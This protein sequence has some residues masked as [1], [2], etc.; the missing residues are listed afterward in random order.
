VDKRIVR[1]IV[2]VALLGILGGLAGCSAEYRPA[3]PASQVPATSPAPVGPSPAPTAAR[4]ASPTALLT[5]AAAGELLGVSWDDRSV[6]RSGLL[7]EAQAVLEHLPGA[8]VYQVDLR[9]P[10]DLN[11]LAGRESV[12]YTNQEAA[13][14][15]EV[16][17]QL[18]PNAAGGKTTV[19][20]VQVNG[21]PVK[22]TLEYE[23]STLRVPLPAA[24]QPGEQAVVTMDFEVEVPREMGGNY[25]LFGYFDGVLVLD[26]FYPVIPVYDDEGWNVQDPPRNADTSYFDMSFYLVRV[27]APAN[28]IL[29]ASGVPVD[30]QRTGQEQVVTLAAGP[31]RDFYIAASAGFTA[32]S[33]TVDGIKV[34]SYAPSDLRP[35]TQ[36][37]LD[38]AARALE[39]YG[40]RFGPYPYTEFDVVSTP[41][42]ALGIEYPGLTGIALSL[43]DLGGNARGTPNSVMVESTVAHEVGHQ[44]FYNLVGNDQIDEPWLDESVVQYVTGLYYRDTYGSSAEQSLQQSWDGRWARVERAA[45]PIGRPAWAYDPKEYSPIIY[46]RGPYF[47]VALEERLGTD[48]FAAF[49]RDYVQKNEWGIGTGDSFRQ[50]AEQHCGCDLGALFQEWVYEP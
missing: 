48:K 22:P 30:S 39:D 25:G 11:L 50:L 8:S 41:M 4:P 33:T 9:I 27:T 37:A 26:E 45:I 34:N 13:P 28:L 43:Y 42:Q 36:L 7:P 2:L 14:L 20:N 17:F 29:V 5:P 10:A 3:Y 19:S 18:F 15:A 23:D 35:G 1:L 24:L 31:M 38:T 46:G 47:L 49:L 32:I 16:Y 21:Q 40:Q 12:R 44:W 6:F